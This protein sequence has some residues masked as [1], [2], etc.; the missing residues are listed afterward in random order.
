M[1]VLELEEF[2][3][4]VFFKEKNWHDAETTFTIKTRQNAHF[5]STNDK[6]PHVPRKTLKKQLSPSNEHLQL[7][8]KLAQWPSLSGQT[9]TSRLQFSLTGLSSGQGVG[10]ASNF[11]GIERSDKVW[12]D[13][14]EIDLLAMLSQSNHV[15]SVVRFGFEVIGW[16][17]WVSSKVGNRFFVKWVIRE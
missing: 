12:G 17:D 8:N 16:E 4:L 2:L 14:T 9:K 6:S 13:C 5:L 3:G 10:R 11:C 7:Q 15:E 1:R